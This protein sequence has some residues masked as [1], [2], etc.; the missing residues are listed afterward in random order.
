MLCIPAL[1]CWQLWSHC[2]PQMLCHRTD[3]WGKTTIAG[4]GSTVSQNMWRS[5]YSTQTV[6]LLSSENKETNKN[7]K[8]Q[9]ARHRIS[10]TPGTRNWV[11]TLGVHTVPKEAS[12]DHTWHVE[13]QTW[14]LFFTSHKIFNSKILFGSSCEVPSPYCHLQKSLQNKMAIWHSAVPRCNFCFSL[15]SLG[16]MLQ[17]II[18]LAWEVCNSQ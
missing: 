13:T 15:L 1:L 2:E 16:T 10:P 12:P 11:A 18:P 4:S 3:S 17:H 7:P 8:G 9:R 6:L 14:V 5:R